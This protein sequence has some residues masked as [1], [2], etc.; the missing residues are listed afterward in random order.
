MQNR[1]LGL[2]FAILWNFSDF[3]G[4]M[5][6]FLC[7]SALKNKNFAVR[8]WTLPFRIRKAFVYLR[9]C[10]VLF[11]STYLFQLIWSQECL[12]QSWP[13]L[14]STSSMLLLPSHLH[15]SSK[16]HPWS[17]PQIICSVTC[18]GRCNFQLGSPHSWKT[19]CIPFLS[20]WQHESLWCAHAPTRRIDCWRYM[21]GLKFELIWLSSA[22]ALQVC[23]IQS[24]DWSSTIPIRS[25]ATSTRSPSSNSDSEA[26]C[27]VIH[28]GGAPDT[29]PW[30][31][32]RQCWEVRV[33]GMLPRGAI[34]THTPPPTLTPPT[35][36]LIPPTLTPTPSTRVMLY[37][38]KK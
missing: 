34:P 26:R 8:I 24:Q 6:F 1:I 29:C 7:E 4:K 37:I 32:V 9:Y 25:L 3:L 18:A 38:Q 30:Q 31:V 2:F 23:V 13:Y 17:F 35:P 20:C 22:W 14:I 11:I 19:F 36:T 33:G 27:S 5:W 16:H 21:R 10:N 28:N 15:P 12:R